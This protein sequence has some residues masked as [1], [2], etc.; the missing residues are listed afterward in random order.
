MR[1][2]E[3]GE[4]GLI[5]R[6]ERLASGVQGRQVVLGIGDD[7]AVLRPRAGEDLVVSTDAHVEGVHF[8][9]SDGSAAGIGHRALAANLS[10]LAA[11]GARPLGFLLAAALP[12]AT[13]VRFA[14]GLLRGMMALAG[15]HACPLVGGN[16]SGGGEIGLTITVL[17]GVKRGRALR[18]DAARVNDRLF[19][20]GALGASARDRARSERSGSPLRHRP[21][22]RIAAGLALARLRQVG[23]CIDVSDGLVA[24]LRHLLDASEVGA[25]V[26]AE[27]LPRA[28]GASDEQALHGGED[29]EL[30][31]TARPGAPS[32]RALTARLD[33][34]VTEIG[35]IT[36]SG[37]EGLAEG[38]SPGGWRHF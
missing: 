2:S 13:E 7:A 11:M 31:F 37:L 20:T 28:R 27:Q 32:A 4:F 17:G 3:L 22:P 8:R 16:V 10:D 5:R 30:L 25:R 24:D 38:T 33:V 34:A 29:Y 18:R 21:A 12:P 6:I 26:D 23:A 9:Q 36:P 19:V 35:C 14:L 15:V 1:V